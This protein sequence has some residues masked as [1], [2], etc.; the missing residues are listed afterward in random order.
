MAAHQAPPSL[1]FSRQE[2]P[3]LQFKYEDSESTRIY[4]FFNK[5]LL[6]RAAAPAAKWL[7]SCPTLCDPIDGSP[8]GSAV[9]EIL[10][11]R[12][13][14]WVAISLNSNSIFGKRELSGLTSTLK[15]LS[16]SIE[17]IK[18]QIKWDCPNVSEIERAY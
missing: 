15:K 16:A 8:P 13:L 2:P 3:K 4:F 17:T 7:Q 9:P 11:A 14:E 12:I 5:Y 6:S 1:G 10:Q 18:S